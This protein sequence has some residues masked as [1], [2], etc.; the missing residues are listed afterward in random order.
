MARVKKHSVIY[1]NEKLALRLA[2]KTL[3]LLQGFLVAV[4]KPFYQIL[5]YVLLVFLG[6]TYHLLQIINFTANTKLTKIIPLLSSTLKKNYEKLKPLLLKSFKI[7]LFL[8]KIA[9]LGILKTTYFISVQL[10][11]LFISQ[12]K[13]TFKLSKKFLLKSNEVISSLHLRYRFERLRK[14]SSTSF[15]KFQKWTSK[16]SKTTFKK[17]TKIQL[18]KFPIIRIAKFKLLLFLI[19]FTFISSLAAGHLFWIYILKDL[20]EPTELTTRTIDVS[21]KIYDRNG[22]LL[23]QIYKDKNR[24]LVKLSDIPLQVRLATLAAEDSDFYYHSGISFKGIARAAI[25]DIQNKELMGGSTITQQLVKNALLSS[26]KT[27]IR[28]FREMVLAFEV[29]MTYSKDQILEMYL[30]EVSYGGTAYGIQEASRTYF[31]KDV[32]N[33][34]L[35]EA[36]LLAGLPK[37]PTLYSPFGPNPEM[38]TQRQHDILGLMQGNGFTTK[39]QTDQALTEKLVF[40]EEKTDIKAPH[41]VMYVRQL[42][43]DTYGKEVVQQGGLEV[44][45]TLDYAIQLLAERVVSE[46]INK[47]KSLH[48]GNSAVLVL[49]PKTGEILAM[50][51]SK[52]YWN[53]DDDG[54][55]NV[56]T[57][58][59]QPGSSIKIV[60][61]TYALSNGYTPVSLILD[62]PITFNIKG[63][64]PYS[65]KNYDGKF[66]GNLT[67]RNAFA[68]S[69]N[70]PAVKVLASYGVNKMIDEGQ[71]MGITSWTDPS[72]YGLSLTLGGGD[73]KLIDLANAY[74][75]IAN[76]GKRPSVNPVLT[77]KNHQGKLLA[78]NGCAYEANKKNTSSST[79]TST[80]SSELMYPCNQEQVVDP[81]VA[82][83]LTDILR[84]NNARAPEFGYNSMLVI[85][86]HPEV[87]VKT[88]TSN[89]LR[90]NL[91]VGY[92]QNYLV[93]VWVG[94]NDNSPMS[95]V[96]SGVTGA[97]PIFNKIMGGLLGDQRIEN[98]PVPDGLVELPIC[99]ITGSLACENCSTRHEWFLKE[100]QPQTVC[101]PDYIKQK[102]E[103]ENQQK[104]VQN[105]NIPVAQ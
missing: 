46:E 103:K 60:N 21:T 30:N 31:G 70:I 40:T 97:S 34:D 3:P 14:T 17:I 18:P 42:L 85:P 81:R 48:V 8:S 20:P 69:R 101:N 12:I 38:A 64:P 22:I 33:L 57:S 62:A 45:T 74:A 67:L 13:S 51:G 79:E 19:M 50:V 91:T 9:I 5:S 78:E 77:V 41:F 29:E 1:T 28:K 90:D 98:W 102:Q 82:Y 86:N 66:V 71:K 58:L 55:V 88:G 16:T 61:Y 25:K 104:I 24:S 56:T 76:Y 26:Q 44:T 96:A 43:E 65:P 105:Q 52:D 15:Q 75:T 99:S 6:I 4:G 93:A 2:K 39:E 92:N 47:L 54:N 84:D 36:A 63:S 32:K 27:L 89:D 37:S 73:V 100:N 68:Q 94:N 72:R 35:A 80:N 53:L 11:K 87:A 23:Y 83:L 7:I 49:N 95:R 59:R 10:T